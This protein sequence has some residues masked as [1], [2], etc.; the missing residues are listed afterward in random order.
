MSTEEEK[1]QALSELLDVLEF[2]V[3]FDLRNGL[4][5]QQY[6]G[7]FYERWQDEFV[8]YRRLFL[9]NVILEANMALRHGVNI[10][11]ALKDLRSIGKEFKDSRLYD[12]HKKTLKQALERAKEV[13]E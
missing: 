6:G 7:G 8:S 4:S 13:L 3:Q 2:S 5:G 9:L 11:K 1:K 10:T 12:A